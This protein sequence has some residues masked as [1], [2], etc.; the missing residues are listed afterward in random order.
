MY[1]CM[2]VLACMNVEKQSQ[3]ENQLFILTN[4]KWLNAVVSIKTLKMKPVKLFFVK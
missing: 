1:M 2:C 3:K 4:I